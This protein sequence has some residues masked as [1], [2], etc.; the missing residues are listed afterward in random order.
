MFIL[1]IHLLSEI[2]TLLFVAFKEK[3]TNED[4]FVKCIG[5]DVNTIHIKRKFYNQTWNKTT[6][7]IQYCSC[8]N[9]RRKFLREG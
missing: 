4:P 6:F 7:P 3:A 5:P 8:V 2:V 1:Q 9:H